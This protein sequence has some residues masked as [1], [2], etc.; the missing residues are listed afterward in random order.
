MNVTSCLHVQLASPSSLPEE[1][2][3]LKPGPLLDD[4][5]SSS[6]TVGRSIRSTTCFA[7]QI[8][9]LSAEM[10]KITATTRRVTQLSLKCCFLFPVEICFRQLSN[11]THA[12]WKVT[13]IA[14][15]SDDS[16]CW[17]M[18]RLSVCLRALLPTPPNSSPA[19]P[20]PQS[21]W[22]PSLLECSWFAIL[23]LLSAPN[24]SVSHISHCAAMNPSGIA[25]PQS[26]AL[27]FITAAQKV[28]AGRCFYM[29]GIVLFLLAEQLLLTAFFPPNM[30]HQAP[31]A[32]S[33]A[34]KL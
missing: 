33:R 6:L 30:S 26:W 34:T 4:S 20:K 27:S 19:H 29:R 25:F 2:L 22:F 3:W 12:W 17:V 9:C 32:N 16:V 18:S 10:T 24:R 8:L 28:P 1:L 15:C 5:V 13:R 31:P 7:R 11:M 23:D 21:R 14:T